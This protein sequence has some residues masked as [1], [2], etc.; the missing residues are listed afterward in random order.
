LSSRC[1]LALGIYGRIIVGFLVGA[2]FLAASVAFV[3]HHH[4]LQSS[5]PCQI[6]FALHLPALRASASVSISQLR[7]VAFAFPIVAHTAKAEPVIKDGPPR[8]PPV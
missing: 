7:V 6:C 8:A 1:R 5:S 2:I 3:D 4:D